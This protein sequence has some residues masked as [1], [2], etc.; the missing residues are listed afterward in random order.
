[1]TTLTKLSA[2]FLGTAFLTL[3]AYSTPSAAH[4]QKDGMQQKHQ[5][6]AN[7]HM[8]QQ[9]QDMMEQMKKDHDM[10]SKMDMSKM[11]M[12]KLSTECQ[13]IMTKMQAKMADKHKDGGMHD[14][15]KDGQ[16]DHAMKDHDMSKMGAHD[17]SKMQENGMMKDHNSTNMK[18]K[19][20]K[21]KQCMAEIKEAM[22]HSH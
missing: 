13:T 4:P 19:M 12:T 1:M 22:P 15:H 16:K 18:A 14:K 6:K 8:G 10:V 5:M 20:A 3:T 21:H 2:V 9:H 17:M 11:D 7:D